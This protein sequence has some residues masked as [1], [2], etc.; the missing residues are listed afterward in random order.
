MSAV[1]G[2]KLLQIIFYEGFENYKY[3]AQIASYEGDLVTSH[4]ITIH[5]SLSEASGRSLQVL[6]PGEYAGALLW[7]ALVLR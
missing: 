1:P 6:L 2:L 3:L 7:A 5:C 4:Q